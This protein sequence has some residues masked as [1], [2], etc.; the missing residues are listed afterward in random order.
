MTISITETMVEAFPPRFVQV[1]APSLHAGIGNALKRAFAVD[2]ETRNRDGF[3]DLLVR[4][5]R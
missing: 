5:E 2:G 4:L 1:A 3:T